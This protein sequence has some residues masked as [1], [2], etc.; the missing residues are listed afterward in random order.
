MRIVA[1]ASVGS[2]LASAVLLLFLQVGAESRSEG[3]NEPAGEPL[4]TF[5]ARDTLGF[6]W[7]E[8][9]LTYRVQF[10]AGR[11]FA[12]SVRLLDDAGV[13]RPCQLSRLKKHSDESIESAR[14]SFRS[15][16]K[17]GGKYRYRLL[18][19]APARTEV[20]LSAVNEERY[21]TL[22][23]RVVSLR[24]PRAGRH[25]FATP[26]AFGGGRATPV[27]AGE[28]QPPTEPIPGPIQ[29]IR[30]ADGQ[31]VGGSDFRCAEPAQMPKAVGYECRITEQGPLFVEAR[32]HYDFDNGGHYAMVARLLAGDPAVR[33][34]EQCDLK[35]TGPA[36]AC[37]IVTSLASGQGGWRPDRVFWGSQQKLDGEDP[38]LEKTLSR[39][40]FERHPKQKSPIGIRPLSYAAPTT[41]LLDLTAW[42]PWSGAAYYFG[43]VESR[44]IKAEPV[45]NH[46]VPFLAVV[47]LH[48]GSWRNNQ[49]RCKTLAT[50]AP[51]E[52]AV[53]WPLLAPPHPA[54]LLHTGEYDP[55]L[56]ATFTRRLW[57]LVAG[58]FQYHGTLFPFREY[59]GNVN[60]DNYK[61]WVLDWPEDP[62]VS[63]PCL[64]LKKRD[65][66]RWAGRLD[67]NPAG[68][69]LR[70]RLFFRDEPGR[71]W[72]LYQS[73]RDDSEWSAPRGQV[74][75]YL[76]GRPPDSFPWH[77]HYRQTQMAG[78]TVGLDELLSSTRLTPGE[79]RD[80][81]AGLAALAYL[82]A[83]P[84]FNPRG[85]MDHLGNPN[86]PINR[87]F[88]LT[89]A[90]ALIPDHPRAKEWLATSAAYVRYKLASNQAPGGAWGELLTYLMP[91]MHI[92]QAAVA[93]GD[94][95]DTAT[96][97]R[98]ALPAKF[99][100]QMLAPPD[101]RFG[102]RTVPNW[103]HE[104]GGVP[105]HW[106]AAAA[107][108]RDLDADLARS[109]V[110][111]WDQVGRPLND[112]HDCGFSPYLAGHSD[113]LNGVKP[114]YTPPE[115]RSAWLPGFGAVLRAHAGD[116]N[117]TFLAYRQ[118]YLTSHSDAN[119]GDFI[120]NAK[121]A[122][123]S[124]L[125][126]EGYAIH[127]NRPF[128]KLNATFGWHNRVRFA[129]QS[130]GGGW[131][132]GGPL[133]QV[134]AHSF[135]DTADYLR[136]LGDYGPQRWSRQILFLKGRAATGPNYFIFR[137]SFPPT[138]GTDK[139][140]PKWWYLRTPGPK[141][142]VHATKDDLN[143][144]S[145]FGARLDVRFL[146]PAAVEIETRDATH[147]GS[148]IG[149][150][151]INWDRAHRPGRKGPVALSANLQLGKG[152]AEETIS[153]SAAGPI[154]AGQDVLV[155]LYPQ[156][157]H[158]AAPAYESLADGAVK[159]I[160]GEGSDYVFAHHR[161][162][163][164]AAGDV[165]F[166]GI[167]GAVR[168]YPDEVHLVIA[169]GP[170]RVE[171]RGTVL[172]SAV[173]AARIIPVGELKRPKSIQVPASVRSI[174]FTLDP[175]AG[176]VEEL[177]PG[178]RRQRRQEGFAME[179]SA[180]EM[181]E[182]GKD[183]VVFR[184][185]RGGIEVNEHKGVVRLVLLDGDK[186]GAGDAQAWG[187]DG[188]YDLTFSRDAVAGKTEGQG[189][190]AYLSKPAGLDRLPE[191]RVDGEP[192]TPGTGGGFLIVP[193]MP[194]AH[195]IE[196]RT[197]PQPP[198]FRSWQMW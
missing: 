126:L 121:G 132:G 60:L 198:V 133:S 2:I 185:R 100:L 180:A 22:D 33:I 127:D 154:A 41:R 73:T 85:S 13:E 186:I 32:V 111:A 72:R 130:N 50:H 94:R 173:P 98:A 55:E 12:D 10:P 184:G 125:S 197:M 93:L 65:L 48:V 114:S 28:P 7:P 108:I 70:D 147:V 102:A 120:L 169:E 53:H 97:R 27:R 101:P 195:T 128:A 172:E 105:S 58:Q 71:R 14:I 134:H 168:V 189:R 30:L 151:A 166:E 188:P 142:R 63:R 143:Y 183:G 11:A 176:P 31:W 148:L 4:A 15:G 159:I 106:L 79:R 47:P 59:E 89:F 69:L 76:Q 149:Q 196:I 110:W 77:S 175:A 86:M 138:A 141:S 6:D 112:Q 190:F 135:S 17:A 39:L 153:V 164:F 131:P 82:M 144:V 96:R 177:A 91:S 140:Q 119:Q 57:A 9:L 139:L 46:T 37:E 192:Y 178:V 80:V 124:T 160:T 179:F 52:V 42:S 191:L 64:A 123:L 103:G 118:G 171:Y 66:E 116:R 3:A 56:P 165:R 49:E 146:Q 158:E 84:D 136:G 19:S 167:A 34:D 61:D 36:G 99:A 152:A 145:E 45:R 51:S 95:L 170:G 83:E 21:L 162:M 181:F 40:G 8:T 38:P 156:T 20:S 107:V 16:L 182:Y 29:G 109:I 174:M 68:D 163:K 26:R 78:Y 193:L 25:R 157:E 113:L 75:S 150:A 18:A 23:N 43:L 62:S 1:R 129:S 115:L 161:P 35:R 67:R 44:S 74:L 187:C 122:P 92:V 90:A 194:G 104:G 24:L 5:E 137:D 54:S 87:F 155:G 117:E 81:R 88:A